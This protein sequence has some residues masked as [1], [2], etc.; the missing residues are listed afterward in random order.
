MSKELLLEIDCRGL[1]LAEKQEIWSFYWNKAKSPTVDLTMIS[2]V[3]TI[4]SVYA[5]GSSGFAG[6]IARDGGRRTL[7]ESS[8]EFCRQPK[9]ECV[10][11]FVGASDAFIEIDGRRYKVIIPLRD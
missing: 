5:P 6:D 11:R 4:I 3:D 1:T 9:F 2:E 8:Y 10:K 7:T